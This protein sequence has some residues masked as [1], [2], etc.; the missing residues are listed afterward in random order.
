MS[1]TTSQVAAL[2]RVLD[3]ASLR[4]RAVAHN[5]ANVNT[6]GYTRREVTFE[7][8]VARIAE[9]DGGPRRADGNNVSLEREMGDLEKNRLL[10]TAAS[11]FLAARLAMLRSAVSGQ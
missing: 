1:H 4:H 9:A 7:H 8:E 2:A 6:P 11:Q 3:H 5:L 10:Y